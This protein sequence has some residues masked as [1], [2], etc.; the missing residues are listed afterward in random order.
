MDLEDQL[1]GDVSGASSARFNERIGT[2]EPP[3]A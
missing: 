1:R 2:D 3:E